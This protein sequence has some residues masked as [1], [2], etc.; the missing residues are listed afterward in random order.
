M[1]A[2]YHS[3]K[4]HKDGHF[5][6]NIDRF[7]L[8]AGQ[9]F[10]ANLLLTDATISLYC[11][12]IPHR[13][14]VFVKL[15]PDLHLEDAPFYYEMQHNN[16]TAVI[17]L[18]FADF[19][20]LAEAI[21]F[22][23]K[24]LIFIHT[25]GRSGSTLLSRAFHQLEHV[26]SYSEPDA[27]TNIA[28]DKDIPLGEIRL[29]LDRCMRYIF[30]PEVAGGYERYVVKF[31]GSC[32]Q[33]MDSFVHVFPE[34]KHLFLYRNA[35]DFA[36]SMYRLRMRRPEPPPIVSRDETIEGF[37]NFMGIHEDEAIR[38]IPDD[39][40]KFDYVCMV[41]LTWSYLMYHADKVTKEHPQTIFALTYDDLNAY[42]EVMMRA[43]FRH[44]DVPLDKIDDS[45][46]AFEQDSQAGTSFAQ[47][48][49]VTLTGDQ[50][51]DIMLFLR[52][53]GLFD[54]YHKIPSTQFHDELFTNYSKHL[55]KQFAKFLGQL[56]V[57]QDNYNENWHYWIV[58]HYHN[59]E[60]EDIRWGVSRLS[61]ENKLFSDSGREQLKKWIDQLLEDKN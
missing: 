33:L 61:F 42:S 3:I 49:R 16:A 47:G 36:R 20:I 60:V 8:D 30:R 14:A 48:D 55:R 34:G 7:E 27:F 51:S 26:L 4:A 18:D 37:C 58:N 25:I 15:P 21:D 10:D 22:D 45:L 19:Y 31:R 29:L 2:T 40:D 24:K 56:I 50:V 54:N 5:I 57:Q 6:S 41:T 17:T 39:M 38:F 44:C 59:E 32:V 43:I 11:L 35:I 53:Q 52:L 28:T 23:Q 12:D 9:P 46:K 13:L 1:S